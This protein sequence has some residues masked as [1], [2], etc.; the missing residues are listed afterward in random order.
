MIYQIKIHIDMKNLKLLMF[1]FVGLTFLTSCSDKLTPFTQRL[2]EEQGWSEAEL[3]KIQFYTS[4]DITLF[5]ELNQGDSKIVSGEIKIR[6]GKKVD[7]VKIRKGTPGVL[8]FQPKE[9][10]F[11]ISFES[12]D[13]EKFLIFG[14]S[15]RRGGRYQLLAKDWKKRGYGKVVYAGNNYRVSSESAYAALLVDLDRKRSTKVKSRTARGRT[16]D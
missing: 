11:A 8:L 6:N 4:D 13:D 12:D 16:V 3:K 14:A 2:Y 10:K 7:E 5:R 15:E 9:D 1:L